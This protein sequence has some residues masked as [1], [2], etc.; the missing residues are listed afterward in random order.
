ML[1]NLKFRKFIPLLLLVG[2]LVLAGGTSLF[3]EAIQVQVLDVFKTFLVSLKPMMANVFIGLIVLCLAY[4]LFDP[5]RAVLERGLNLTSADPRRRTIVLRAV[6]LVYWTVAVFV[7]VSFIAPS[8]LSQFVVGFGLL[9]AALTLSLKGIA[10]DF[11]AGILLNFSPKCKVGDEIELVGI[12]VEG[13][14]QDIGF[15]LTKIE[16]PEG[17]L[18]VPNRELWDRSVNVR[19]PSRPRPENTAS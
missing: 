13:K 6:S 8:F 5:L 12:K 14:V 7:G 11:I 1:K 4:S 9:G 18:S 19:D 16:G 17:L 2:L 3:S 10:N 15:V